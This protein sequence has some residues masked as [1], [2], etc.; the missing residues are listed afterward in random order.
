[1]KCCSPT[2]L[3][4]V[5]AVAAALGG[6]NP[7]PQSLVTIMVKWLSLRNRMGRPREVS[8][9]CRAEQGRP[10]ARQRVVLPHLT[11]DL[12][13]AFPP[14]WEPGKLDCVSFPCQVTRNQLTI[15]Q[16]RKGSSSQAE[17]RAVLG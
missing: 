6:S 1:M 13:W 2:L 8:A 5:L 10:N 16:D 7:E 9:A 12:A 4:Q 11:L 3:S 15:V 14:H 17:G